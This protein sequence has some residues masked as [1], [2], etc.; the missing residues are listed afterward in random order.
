MRIWSIALVCSLA[1]FAAQQTSTATE[2]I[3]TFGTTVVAT[4]GLRGDIYLLDPGTEFLPSFKHR[5]PVGAVYT[6][7]LNIPTRDFKEGFP[8]VT[9]R[10]EWFAID[11]T[12][13]FFVETGARYRFGLESDDGSKLYIDRHLIIDNDGLHSPGGCAGTVELGAGIHDI[14]VSYFQGPGWQVALRL[15][16]S[17]IGQPWRIFNTDEFAPPQGSAAWTEA[18]H[19][20]KRFRKL[21]GGD[22]PAG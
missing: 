10:L 13:T 5:K 3:P 19:A 18:G 12:G 16:I 17:K 22:C 4:S 6:N 15:L 20:K 2:Q 21:R 7:K 14:R 8:G 1:A 9:G 11:Y